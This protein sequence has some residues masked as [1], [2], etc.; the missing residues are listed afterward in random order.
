MADAGAEPAPRRKWALAELTWDQDPI[1]GAQ[2]NERVLRTQ[3]PQEVVSDPGQVDDFQ[4]VVRSGLDLSW[5][6]QNPVNFTFKYYMYS[7]ELITGPTLYKKARP[8]GK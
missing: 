4:T 6:K 3:E 5:M 7:R 8:S 2:S 1:V